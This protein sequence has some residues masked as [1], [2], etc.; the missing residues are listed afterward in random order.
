MPF[1]DAAMQTGANA[2][3]NA[4]THAQL[5]SANP[6][7]GVGS[8]QGARF[9]VA[10]G[11]ATADGDFALTTPVTKTGLTANVAIQYVSFWTASTAGTWMGTFALTGDL[12]ANAAGEYIL[13]A[14]T[15]NGSTT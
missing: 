6:T 10:M 2:I 1:S 8:E 14:F 15:A 9:A 4:I 13:N 3:R 12:T 7:S 11:A 5:H